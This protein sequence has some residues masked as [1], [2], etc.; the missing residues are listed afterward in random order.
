MWLNFVLVAAQTG[1][2]L[3]EAQAPGLWI[4]PMPALDLT[5]IFDAVRFKDTPAEK[6]GDGANLA[7][8]RSTLRPQPW[9]AK[10]WAGCSVCST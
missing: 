5:R 8:A 3:V 4:S 7:S 1:V 10:W 6:L 2:F 9:S